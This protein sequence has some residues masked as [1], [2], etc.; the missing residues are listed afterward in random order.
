MITVA[1]RQKQ[2]S[3]CQGWTSSAEVFGLVVTTQYSSLHIDVL[4][5]FD[6]TM[7]VRM[8]NKD[9]SHYFFTLEC[10]SIF[11]MWPSIIFLTANP[12]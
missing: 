9:Q 11:Y 12:P 7:C 8:K 2:L 1:G 6:T 10:V 5:R 4:Q 3:W